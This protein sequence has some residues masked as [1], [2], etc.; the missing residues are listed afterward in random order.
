[1]LGRGVIASVYGQAFEQAGHDVV[2]HVRPGRTAEYREPLAMDVLDG[3]RGPVGR[4]TCTTYRPRLRET[5]EP[6]DGVDL[7][8]LSVGHHQL[9]E[10]AAFLAPRIGD[11]TVVVLGNVW[12]ELATAVAPIP[13]EQVVFGFPGAGG[14]FGADGTLHGAVLRSITLGA[15]VT[16]SD[17][18]GAEARAA[19]R[20]AGFTLRDEGD[21][22]GWLLL[23]FVLDAGM[24]SQALATGGLMNMVG[25]RRALREAFRTARE[26]LPVI[27]AR[28]V[29]LARHRTA[30]MPTRFPGVT[31]AALGLATVVVPMARA[32]LA[33]HGDP[34]AAE[35]RAVLR[36]VTRTA[37]ASGI[38]TPRLDRA[39]HGH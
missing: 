19:F 30:V 33:A 6:D 5:S 9:Q 1:M 35:P 36:D 31:G 11:A 28:G 2:H 25:D 16:P 10:A 18:R 38:A 23:H 39:L 26:L 3:R 21:I 24:F 32:T 15:A 12:D 37:R 22:R 20:Q 14:G 34:H 13:V 7:V 27:E 4:R 17:R 29:D 8:V